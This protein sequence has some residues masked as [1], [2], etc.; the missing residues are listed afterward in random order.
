[1]AGGDQLRGWKDIAAF[2][3]NVAQNS[4]TASSIII[5]FSLERNRRIR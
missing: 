2:L 5:E 4:Q 1:M 3:G